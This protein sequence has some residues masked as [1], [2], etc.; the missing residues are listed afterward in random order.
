MVH[1]GETGL[2]RCRR[3]RSGSSWIVV[4]AVVGRTQCSGGRLN[5]DSERLP[6]AGIPSLFAA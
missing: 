5:P 3:R 4:R 2:N 6:S 1:S